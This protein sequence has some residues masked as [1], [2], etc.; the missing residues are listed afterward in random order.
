MPPTRPMHRAAVLALGGLLALAVPPVA[1]CEA[2]VAPAVLH[3]ATAGDVERFAA[4]VGKR[5]L[6]FVGY[7]GQGYEDPAAMRAAAARVLDAQDPARVMVNVGATAEGI[8]AVY[9]VARER[10]FATLGIVSSLAHDEGVPLSRCVQQVFF[11]RDAS[12]GG[13]QP[14]TGAL[15]P[16]SAA[17]VDVS[18]EIVAIGGGD[19]ARDE[20]LAARAAGKPVRFIPADMNHAAARDKARRRGQA[21]PTDFLGSAHAALVGR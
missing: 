16:T 21:E 12:W 8:G 14:G 4:R 5:V 17:I 20:A 18:S 6:T 19:V 1:A 15:S 7:S 3:G 10:G 11:I 9:E 13:R 2:S